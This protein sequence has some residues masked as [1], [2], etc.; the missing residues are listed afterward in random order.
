MLSSKLLKQQATSYT[1]IVVVEHKNIN[2]ACIN[3]SD[4]IIGVFKH[5]KVTKLGKENG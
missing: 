1:A 2:F 3:H 5:D 4:L